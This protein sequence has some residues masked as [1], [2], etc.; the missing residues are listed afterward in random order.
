[1][2]FDANRV[3]FY[4]EGFSHF[5]LTFLAISFVSGYID[6]FNQDKSRFFFWID[7]SLLEQKNGD[8][9]DKSRTVFRVHCNKLKYSYLDR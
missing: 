9:I 1:M 7:K 4:F 2:V 6:L 5:L 8:E 3:C